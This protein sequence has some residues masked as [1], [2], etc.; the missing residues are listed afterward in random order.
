LPAKAN[1]KLQEGNSNDDS[2]KTGT[3]KKILWLPSWYPSEIDF[4]TGDFI[5]RHARAVSIFQPLTIIYL[6]KDEK[7]V[8][9]SDILEKK[10]VHGNLQEIIIY[11]KPYSIGVKAIDKLLSSARYVSVY[12]KYI[13]KYISEEGMP[14]FIHVHVPMKA[15]V[16]ALWAKRKYD[17]PFIVTEHWC[18]Y[19]KLNPENFFTRNILFRRLTKKIFQSATLV[20]MVCESNRKELLSLFDIEKST[21]IQN[22]ADR[23]LFYFLNNKPALPPFIF[24]HVSSLSY[25]KNAEGMLKAFAMLK[26]NFQHWRCIIIGPVNE[27]LKQLAVH[28]GL[29][30]FLEW[31]GELPNKAVASQ[32]QN[33]HCM[34]MFSR[35]ENSPCTIIE[36]LSAGVPVIATN[37]G[38]IPEI[39]DESNG[40]LVAS[41]DIAGL[42]K[43]M[44]NMIHNY[45]L[46]KR[47][48]I[49]EK[50]NQVFSY[51]IVGAAITKLYNES[52]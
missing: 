37:V 13:R 29:E 30:D 40:L 39:L 8:L 41:E 3:M 36:A 21:I 48:A 1:V 28:Y 7:G 18:A 46:Y 19:N 5:Q 47:H 2:C 34:V 23:H 20:T 50:A 42:S 33:V 35:Y 51:E 43:A 6:V 52:G 25:Q 15:G 9:T 26:V 17:I 16:L 32:M 45:Q 10:S 11:Y 44:E 24:V 22:V 14:A 4:F 12:R 27:S 38:G 49:A 31:T